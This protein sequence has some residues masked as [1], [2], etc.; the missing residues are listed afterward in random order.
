MKEVASINFPRSFIL[1]EVEFKFNHRLLKV[2]ISILCFVYN[3]ISKTRLLVTLC[4]VF[5][6]WTDPEK[7]PSDGTSDGD[8]CHLC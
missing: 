8:A 4:E 1:N 5:E 2:A 6:F 7:K 3:L